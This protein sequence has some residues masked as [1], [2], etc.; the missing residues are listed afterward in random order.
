MSQRTLHGIDE[1][2]KKEE[3]GDEKPA[4]FLMDE[5]FFRGRMTYEERLRR[6]DRG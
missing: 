3:A 1:N 5:R 4:S 6:Y 2:E